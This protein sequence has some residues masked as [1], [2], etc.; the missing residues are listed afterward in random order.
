LAG[1]TDNEIEIIA[2]VARY[3]RKSMPKSSHAEF[4]RLTAEGQ[5][6]VRALAGILRIAIGLDR[7]HQG[8]VVGLSARQTNGR[9]EITVMPRPERDLSLE[10]YTAGERTALLEQ[11]FAMPVELVIGGREQATTARAETARTS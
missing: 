6:V 8:N 10:L 4:N 7:S 11:V 9:L 5:H 1:L 2:L 3:H